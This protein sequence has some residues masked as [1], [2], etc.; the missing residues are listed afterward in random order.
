[1]RLEN[2]LFCTASPPQHRHHVG[3]TP[4]PD[5]N[6]LPSD[7]K[8]TDVGH[9]FSVSTAFLYLQQLSDNPQGLRVHLRSRDNTQLQSN[10][11][12]HSWSSGRD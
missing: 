8:K 7:D 6:A 10:M 5:T 11:R 1:M 12:T 9:S 2:V 3:L 4:H